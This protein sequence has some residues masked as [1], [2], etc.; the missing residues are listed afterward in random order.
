M[1]N[2]ALIIVIGLCLAAAGVGK[3]LTYT[4]ASANS[5]NLLLTWG[6][7]LGQLLGLLLL[8]RNGTI[9]GTAYAKIILLLYGLLLIGVTFKILH[10]LGADYLLGS[11]LAGIALTY[12]IRFIRKQSKG[13]LDS[14]KLLLV[15]AACGSSLLILSHLAPREAAYVAPTLLWLAVLDFMYLESRKRTMSSE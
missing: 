12:T 11:A 1:N 6:I 7:G 15:L 9:L 3:L 4:P 10:W 13:Q 2:R 5:G 14:L 8:V